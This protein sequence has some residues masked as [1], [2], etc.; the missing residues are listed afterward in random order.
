M[1]PGVGEDVANVLG[2]VH[3]VRLGQYITR[4]KRFRNLRTVGTINFGRYET[5]LISYSGLLSNHACYL[6]LRLTHSS[7]DGDSKRE[8][9]SRCAQCRVKEISN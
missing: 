3:I 7:F 4:E 5:S 2:Y 6:R 9:P 8:H 1:L